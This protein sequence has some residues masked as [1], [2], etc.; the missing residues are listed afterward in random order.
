MLEN[1]QHSCNTKSKGMKALRNWID[2]WHTSLKIS[3]SFLLMII[4]GFIFLILPVSQAPGSEATLFDHFFH[5]VSLVTVTGLVIHPIAHTYS[6][7]GQIVSLVLMQ[8]GGLGIMTIVASA[9]AFMGKKMNLRNR[10]LVQASINRED[11]TDFRSFMRLIFRYVLVFESLGFILLSFRF[12]P[13]MGWEKGLFTALYMAVSAFTNGGFDTLGAVSLATYVHDPLVNIVTAVLI[14]LGGIGFHVWFD[15]SNLLLK[16][17]QRTKR[18]HIRFFFRELTLHSRLALTVSALLIVS[19][20]LTFL[21]VEFSNPDTIGD[22]SF[23]Q[24]L[25]ASFFQTVTMRTAGMTTI[26]FTKVHSFTIF[27]FILSMFVGGSPG[28]TAG[29]IKTTTFAMVVLL[30]INESKGQKNVNIWNYTLS[31]NLVRSAVVIFLI[32]LAVFLAGTG[33]LSLLNPK[34]DFIVLMFESVSAITTV[35]M[36]A[37]LTPTLDVLS[38]I[39]LML[40]MFIGRIGPITMAETLAR[41]DKETKNIQFTEGKVILG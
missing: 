34:V 39:I 8:I 7:F 30:I 18:R 24:K 41:K 9:I 17:P 16:W 3:V 5:A 26:D 25:L 13:Q 1:F 36:S 2:G 38:R 14:I 4:I 32:F 22:F 33:L 6:L 40:L 23:G 11:A 20:T 37:R 10:M 28:S 15:V 21:I 19:G 35:G 12:V 31:V 27:S 29:G